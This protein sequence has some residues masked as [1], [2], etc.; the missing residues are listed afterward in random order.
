MFAN[1][2]N[3]DVGTKHKVNG[4]WIAISIHKEKKKIEEPDDSGII[5]KVIE[6]KN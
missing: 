1:D 5:S 3:I 2:A 4:E 6:I